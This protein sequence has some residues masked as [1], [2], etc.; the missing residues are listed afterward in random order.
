[1]ARKE[2]VTKV[3][4]GD[5]FLTNRRTRPVRLNGVDTPE[6]GEKRYGAAK[7]QL[8]SLIGGQ[9]VTVDTK[10]RDKYGR[11]VANVKIEGTSVNQ[12]MKG[13]SK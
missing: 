13:R 8:Q 10:A 11:S 7:S 12:K 3:F 1:M 6:R 9:E 4:D 2:K 5:T